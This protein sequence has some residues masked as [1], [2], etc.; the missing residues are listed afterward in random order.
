MYIKSTPFKGV[1]SEEMLRAE[2][3]N[4]RTAGKDTNHTAMLTLL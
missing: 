2:P 1:T 3:R 4:N